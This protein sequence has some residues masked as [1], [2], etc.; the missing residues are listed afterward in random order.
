MNT[1]HQGENAVEQSGQVLARLPRKGYGGQAQELRISL[2]AYNGSQF[3]RLQVWMDKGSGWFPLPSKLV[4]IRAVELADALEALHEAARMIEAEGPANPRP[5]QG[6]RPRKD[7]ARPQAY[8][9]GRDKPGSHWTDT[10]PK[11][12]ASIGVGFDEFG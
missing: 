3:V 2:D 4:T 6:E 1:V 11:P 5:S 10:L 9:R 7:Q 8:A 12:D